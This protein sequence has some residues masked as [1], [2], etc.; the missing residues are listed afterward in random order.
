MKK[1]WTAVGLALLLSGGSGAFA[2]EEKAK[3]ISSRIKELRE[4]LAGFH[5]R[6]DDPQKKEEAHPPIPLKEI[7]PLELTEHLEHRQDAKMVVLFHDGSDGAAPGQSVYDSQKTDGG[8]VQAV[9]TPLEAALKRIQEARA[10]REARKEIPAQMA[11]KPPEN[12]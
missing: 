5:A 4:R 3:D 7:D 12:K 9:C 10:S 6:L 2:E 11:S 8:I 1:L